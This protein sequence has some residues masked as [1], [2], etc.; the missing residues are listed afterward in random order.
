MGIILA[1]SVSQI[2]IISALLMLMLAG[3]IVFFVLV[4]QKKMIRQEIAIERMK[5][6]HQR[7]LLNAAI[8][9]QEKERQ[10]IAKDLHDEVGAMLSVIKMGIAQYERKSKEDP[11]AREL[12]QETKSQV[13]ETIENVRRISKDLMPVALMKMGLGFALQAMF[14]KLQ[15]LE[16]VEVHYQQAGEAVR[17]K[18]STALGLYRVIQESLNNCLKHAQASL[19]TCDLRYEPE[20]LTLHFRDNGKGF[21]LQALLHSTDSTKGL[22]LKSIESR[23]NILGGH[24]VHE[25]APG[26]GTSI[27]ISLPLEGQLQPA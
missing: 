23:V 25:S 3:V 21:D 15:H 13:T 6:E 27:H 11:V 20:Q 14:D 24:L 7:S 17:L 5:T 22:G 8:E 12:A 2:F 26:R 19:I 18:S 16:G 10:R 9:T 1:T 4:Y